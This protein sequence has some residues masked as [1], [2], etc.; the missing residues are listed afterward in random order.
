MTAIQYFYCS[1]WYQ[2]TWQITKEDIL[3]YSHALYHN[4]TFK[5]FRGTVVNKAMPSL[6]M[7]EG[8]LEITLTVPLN[9]FLKDIV[10]K[11]SWKDY[12]KSSIR[13]LRTTFAI[14]FLILFFKKTL[15]F[16]RLRYSAK[17]FSLKLDQHI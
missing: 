11:V 14:S 8:S 2:T 5:G 10:V 13:R 12:L 3:N 17:Q 9:I 1:V 6:H 15:I 7:I 4:Y 16:L